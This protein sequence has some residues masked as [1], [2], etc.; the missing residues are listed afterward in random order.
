M[1][2]KELLRTCYLIKLSDKTELPITRLNAEKIM[3]ILAGKNKPQFL[4]IENEMINTSFIIGIA[5]KDMN[6]SVDMRQLTEKERE[7]HEQYNKTFGSTL[8]I[9][10]GQQK[11]SNE[12]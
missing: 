12:Q 7:T 9:G 11:I 2:T 8:L 1:I 5:Y 3:L 10:E 4:F 6:Y